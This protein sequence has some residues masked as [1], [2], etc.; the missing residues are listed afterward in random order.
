MANREILGLWYFVF[1]T[2]L[3]ME[4]PIRDCLQV[5]AKMPGLRDFSNDIKRA[6]RKDEAMAT[7]M[8]LAAQRYKFTWPLFTLQLINVGE[9]TGTLGDTCLAAALGIY[10][11]DRR[12]LY[13]DFCALTGLDE[14]WRTCL[15]PLAGAVGQKESFDIVLQLV[16]EDAT[17]PK[18]TFDL[19]RVS[20][21]SA[22]TLA[23]AFEKYGINTPLSHPILQHLLKAGEDRGCIDAVFR[24]LLV[25]P[26]EESPARLP[27]G[28]DLSLIVDMEIM[29]I[30]ANSGFSREIIVANAGER[31]PN[32]AVFTAILNGLQS[33]EHQTISSSIQ[34]N[35]SNTPLSSPEFLSALEE[36]ERLGSI[37][38]GIRR[39][40][41]AE[42]AA[43]IISQGLP[44]QLHIFYVLLNSGMSILE[45]LYVID[46]QEHSVSG[47]I[48]R[49]EN[50]LDF[51]EA[52]DPRRTRSDTESPSWLENELIY[53]FAKAGQD[54]Y[55]LAAVLK[56][57]SA[58]V[59]W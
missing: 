3:K 42:V 16:A 14:S 56:T 6:Y 20:D 34:A 40:L 17:E 49:M 36:G 50:G 58:G 12:R 1:G 32:E 54:T 48:E 43:K 11:G 30:Y 7:S 33:G 15:R 10:D 21:Q 24:N 39:F 37:Y 45:S 2:L 35:A 59:S 29:A 13:Q 57:L 51:Y 23:N 5:V 22:I 26:E 47:V 8:L 53:R 28:F 19:A 27:D 25:E 52:I 41:P 31:S 9:A 18:A 38:D 44:R 4:V 55:C 46:E